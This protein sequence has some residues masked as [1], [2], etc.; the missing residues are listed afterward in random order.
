M[1]RNLEKRLKIKY[2][3]GWKKNN[4]ENEKTKNGGLLCKK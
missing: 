1:R 2:N 3:V 4:A